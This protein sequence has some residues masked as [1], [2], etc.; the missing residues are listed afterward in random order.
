MHEMFMDPFAS[1]VYQAMIHTLT[2]HPRKNLGE[3]N[4]TK[5]RKKKYTEETTY[6]VPES[7]TNTLAKIL[8]TVKEWELKLL[9]SLVLDKYAVPLMQVIAES[10]VVK[11]SKKKSK[12]KKEVGSATLSDIILF[13]NDADSKG[14]CLI[15]READYQDNKDLS[16]NSSRIQLEVVYWK[17]LSE[18]LPMRPF[19]YCSPSTS[20]NIYTISL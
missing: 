11:K 19:S 18:Q 12:D 15:F 4:G 8:K 3:G 5:K 14:N 1:H 10:D 17:L 16:I 7:F 2:G 9:Q 13:G 20:K 6:Q